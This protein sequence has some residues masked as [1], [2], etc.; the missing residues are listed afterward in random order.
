[1]YDDSSV[2]TSASHN[3]KGVWL[4]HKSFDSIYMT[5]Q[6]S[7]KGFCKN[8][9]DFCSIQSTCPFPRASKRVK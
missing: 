4:A 5:L 8:S 7:N 6:S 9:A 1:M 3:G 2:P